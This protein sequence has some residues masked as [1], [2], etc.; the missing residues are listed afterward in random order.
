M[1]ESSRRTSFATPGSISSTVPSS[2]PPSSS[3]AKP[4]ELERV[5]AAL[6]GRRQ[7][8]L[9]QLELG[10]RARR[11]GRADHE[12]P[13]GA[14]GRDHLGRLARPRRP[15]R[16]R[17]SARATRSGAR[18][19]TSPSQ[20]VRPADP[21]DRDPVAHPTISSCRR[22]PAFAPLARTRMRSERTI[23][24]PRPIT[25]PRSS[26]ATCSSK[27]TASSRSIALDPH[28]ARRRRRGSSRRTSSSSSTPAL[29]RRARGGLHE[30]L[31]R[32]ARLRAL[33]DPVVD[34]GLVEIDRGGVGLRV[35]APDDLDEPAVARRAAVG[36]DDPVD[37]ILL[38]A[39]P[40]QPDACSH[41]SP[42]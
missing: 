3:T 37:R 4:A 17:R 1:P 11:R 36:D 29:T 32:V 6:V 10:C 38:R 23:R 27:T 30:A 13:A 34:L 21:A 15:A 8:G 14:L 20:P 16:R 41:S 42:L 28:L 31:H 5:V 24:P 7:L 18:R 33:R 22:S 2:R 12:A 9:R 26:S 25:L 39:H 40:G 19:R 35:V